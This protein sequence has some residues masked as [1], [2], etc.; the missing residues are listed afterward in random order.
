MG[1][2]AAN[3]V[4]LLN[5]LLQ[6]ERACSEQVEADCLCLCLVGERTE[7]REITSSGGCSRARAAPTGSSSRR[8]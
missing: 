5:Q 4:I 7:D 2:H 8:E 3:S 6:S 1:D